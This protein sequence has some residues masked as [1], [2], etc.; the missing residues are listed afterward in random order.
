MRWV[1]L[2]IGGANLKAADGSGWTCSRPFALWKAPQRLADELASLLAGVEPSS[3]LAVT[4]TGELADC[5]RTKAEG[6]RS[7]LSAVETAAPQRVVRVYRTDGIFCPP[8]QAREEPL[9]VAAANW[10]ATARWAGRLV[11]GQSA[12]LIDIGSTTTDIIPL[13]D[14]QPINQGA[15][16]PQR[17]LSGELVYTGVT[18][19]PV[20]ALVRELPW[21]NGWCPVAQE[22]FATTLDAYL[23]LGDI[24]EDP[25]NRHTAD[26][27]PATREASH[28]R[29]ARTICADRQLF[30]R[31]D[32]LVAA[33]A[34]A[35]AQRRLL[36]AALRSVVQ[37][38]PALPGTV[39]LSGQGEFLG[40]RLAE[41]VLGSAEIVS[42][43][44]RLGSG[45][46]RCA[47]AHAVAVLAA[48]EHPA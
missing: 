18:R 16:D 20:C 21:H 42:I 43:E 23:M 36:V 35:Q 38:L 31:A 3:G 33:Q 28:D 10:H 37:R 34:I 45:V 25:T 13:H 4:M 6:V 39:V 8:P 17:L 32:A 22:F 14:G 15:T 5:Y 1:G 12:V 48:E 26:G 11:P 30:S 40:R 27:R 19:S 24:P 2:D 29:L 7:I 9:R 47:A 44:A 46:S 41:K